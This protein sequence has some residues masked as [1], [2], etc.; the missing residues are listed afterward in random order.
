VNFHH[1]QNKIATSIFAHESG[2]EHY[3]P[4]P[5]PLQRLANLIQNRRVVDGRR[6]VQ[7]SW[8]AIV[9][10]VQRRILPERVLGSPDTMIAGT[11]ARFNRLR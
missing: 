8:S 6:H 5:V 1:S 2:N 7:G 10:R 11:T 9:L 4:T 3:V